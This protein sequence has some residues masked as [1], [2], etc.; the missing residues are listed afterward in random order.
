MIRAKKQDLSWFDLRNYDFLNNLTLP[1]L[2][3]EL[4]WRNILLNS[5]GDDID[6]F[7][8]EYEIKYE[9]IFSGDPNLTTL[10]SEEQEATDFI[11]KVNSEVPSLRNLYGELP[12][13][14]SDIGVSPLSFTELSMYS[15]SAIDQGFF[16]RDE[17]NTYI[18]TNSMLAS[19]SGNLSDCFSSNVLATIDLDDATDDEIITSLTNLLP[20]WRKKLKVPEKD[21]I[22]R[23]RIGIKTIQKLVSNRVLPIVD[24]LIWGEKVG[25]EVTNPMISALAFS[26][27]PKDTQ[28]IKESIK[29]FAIESISQQY[30][31]LLELYV[32]KDK[33]I[34][35]VKIS[36]LMS[37]DL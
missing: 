27:D 19:V 32:K 11:H 3:E 7:D 31:R 37:R 6:I 10:N 26:D 35:L 12:K 29:P 36:D 4:E 17:E 25:K 30:T 20:L 33:E 22:A 23:K 1:V 16:K 15:F 21:H 24:L 13:L 34:S 5:I 18:K 28:A 9:R 2:I 14:S 8:K